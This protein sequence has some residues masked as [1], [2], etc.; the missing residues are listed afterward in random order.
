MARPPLHKSKKQ[1]QALF[2]YEL[3]PINKVAMGAESIYQSNRLLNFDDR[4]GPYM[5]KLSRRSSLHTRNNSLPTQQSTQR[6]PL[7][8][9]MQRNDAERV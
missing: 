7:L 2:D 1:Q 9:L 3:E 6:D 5:V 4:S 8:E